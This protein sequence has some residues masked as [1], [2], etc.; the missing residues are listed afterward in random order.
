[1]GT[2]VSLQNKEVATLENKK[3]IVSL[4]LKDRYIVFNREVKYDVNANEKAISNVKSG[5]R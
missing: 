3:A 4:L 5:A 1:M 2:H